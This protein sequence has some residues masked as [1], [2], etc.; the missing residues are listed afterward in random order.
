M[1]KVA[2]EIFISAI[3]VLVPTYFVY[4]ELAPVKV[5]WDSQFLWSAALVICWVFVAAG[6]Y[7]QGWL[8]RKE[9]HANGVS[10]VLPIFVFFVQCILFVKGI[11]Y[12]DQS[13]VIGAVLV[14][15]GVLFSLYNIIRS[16]K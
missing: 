11:Y 8:V 12:R 10:I 6:Y 13:L 5:F 4:Q 15:S 14:N 9:G 1:K 16:K 3:L 2:L 7:H